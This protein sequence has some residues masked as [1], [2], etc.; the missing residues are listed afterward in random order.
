M[1]TTN[2]KKK[3]SPFSIH[4]RFKSFMGLYQEFFTDSH[5]VPT[6]HAIAD[7]KHLTTPDTLGVSCLDMISK[8]KLRL[9]C[10][11]TFALTCLISPI[12]YSQGQSVQSTPSI[13]LESRDEAAVDAPFDFFGPINFINDFTSDSVP[14]AA[15]RDPFTNGQ[16]AYGIF[17]GALEIQSSV[18][19]VDE[20]G[21]DRF[22]LT[23]MTFIRRTDSYGVDVAISS[24]SRTNT[25]GFPVFLLS[26]T[27]YNDT[28]AGGGGNDGREGDIEA[29]LRIDAFPDGNNRIIAELR[30]RDDN[31][32]RV[33]IPFPNGED[34]FRFT[35]DVQL[36][37][38]YSLNIDFDRTNGQ[39]A[40]SVGG[41]GFETIVE[42]VNIETPI[43]TPSRDS[44]FLAIGLF[45]L[46]TGGPV[47]GRS[48]ARISEIR[49][50]GAM[51]NFSENAPTL[52]GQIDF[53]NTV[54]SNTEL[55]EG[56]LRLTHD[57]NIASSG[58]ARVALNGHTDYVGA[59]FEIASNSTQVDGGE[60]RA[61]VSSTLYK[62]I[63]G[64]FDMFDETGDVLASLRA[65]A[66][67]TE[68]PIFEVCAFRSN[69]PDFNQGSELISMNADFFQT[70]NCGQ[71][72]IT[73]QFDTPYVT[74]IA[75]D[76]ENSTITYRVQE[77]NNA[78]VS[79]EFVFNITSEI[80]PVSRSFAG[81]RAQSRGGSSIES[82]L[83]SL[84]FAPQG[85]AVPLDMSNTLLTGDITAAVNAGTNSANV[86]AEEMAPDNTTDDT[87]A[88]DSEM[89]D[90]TADTTDTDL[91]DDN[92]DT[93]ADNL[94]EEVTGTSGG[95]GGCT[96][97]GSGS[98]DPLL[99]LLAISAMLT[100]L[101]RRINI[102]TKS[103]NGEAC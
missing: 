103:V 65:V 12:A 70:G 37:T 80:F 57:S 98:K 67:G 34:V 20:G 18:N 64:D 3:K 27:L 53:G 52:V 94:V 59:T 61:Q 93:V 58:D 42:T 96:I 79:D 31:G 66:R 60:I 33:R 22:T 43:L 85:S 10:I 5:P 78:A 68:S 45:D 77:L 30:R 63:A 89:P 75:L 9:L 72:N 101:L 21:D 50:G 39:I 90:S 71:M 8:S 17:D 92:A 62:D 38:T 16:S 46:G 26:G 41:E 102:R 55:E 56:R 49:A 87:D 40:F 88:T 99:P 4:R 82:F 28:Q 23:G 29:R 95:G 76:R 91:P 36:D 44:Q 1:L 7:I 19:E 14:F 84:S 15:W 97:G 13:I 35:L 11:S 51:Y 25:D 48:I 74:S 81:Y 69:D 100:L 6:P 73:P 2:P 83:S 54:A 24:R 47:V 32:S 86:V